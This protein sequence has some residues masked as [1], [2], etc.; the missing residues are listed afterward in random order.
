MSSFRVSW[1]YGSPLLGEA[2]ARR[3]VRIATAARCSCLA[4]HERVSLAALAIAQLAAG[5]SAD[6][7]AVF[8]LA[9]FAVT[10]LSWRIWR[11]GGARR[12]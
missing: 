10:W 3:R 4:V 9:W 5:P 1:P 12:A 11:A 7:A 2:V 6:V 8:A